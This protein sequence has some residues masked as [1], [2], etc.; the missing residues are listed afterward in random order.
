MKKIF[1][2]HHAGGDKYAYR[3]LQQELSSHYDTIA[4]EIPGR[5][6]RYAEPLL[7]DMH[8]VVD[9]LYV[10]IIQE[11]GG[12]DFAL[13]GVSMGALKAFLL[14]HRFYQDKRPIPQHLFLASRKSILGYRSH[15]DIASLQTS[16]FWNGVAKYGGISKQLLA[17]PE[18]LALY[19]PILRADFQVL[20]NFYDHD[21]TPLP[22]PASILIGR[23]DSITLEDIVPWQ[24]YF[25]PTIETH[26]FEGGHFFVYEQVQSIVE[27]VSSR[28]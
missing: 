8:S 25:T 11:I 13:L 1:L 12:A 24:S 26:I 4:L 22:V 3:T 18:L 20:E 21:F 15:A 16:D 28:F 19:E 23:D 17:Q 5:G 9:D 2:L 7:Q 27:Y 10:Q 6:D 14:T